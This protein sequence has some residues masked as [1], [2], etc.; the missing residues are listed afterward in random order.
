MRRK[1]LFDF[2]CFFFISLFIW[3]LTGAVFLSAQE[4][5]PNP[6]LRALLPEMPE[7][8][9]QDEPRTYFPGT[10]YEY[11]DGASEAYLSYDFKELLVAEYQKKETET[12][13]T[14]EIYDMGTPINAFGIFSSE[15]YPESPEAGIGNAGYLE[16]EVLNFIS[17]RYYVK[18]LCYNGEEETPSYLK[19]FAREIEGKIK[20]KASLPE[21]FRYF[22]AEGRVKNSEKFIKKN[23]MGFDFLQNGYAV[24]YRQNE[25]EFDGFIIEA[26]SVTEAQAMLQKILDFYAGE[27][28]PFV[29]EG[30]KY[31]QTNLYG[32]QVF[33]GQ[34]KN[35]IF[36]FSRIPRDLIPLAQS[37]FAKLRQALEA[38][39]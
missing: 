37:N 27:K 7:W 22:P 5:K 38:K 14:V 2:I 3:S 36:G 12:T 23:F 13:I 20:D 21:I 24:L 30:D 6:A 32:Q 25:V 17:G 16:D 18:L 19:L 4:L 10:L 8:V 1:K 35:Y 31:R 39:K 28:V 11:I 26:G 29:K 15:R 9:L 33:L 34:V